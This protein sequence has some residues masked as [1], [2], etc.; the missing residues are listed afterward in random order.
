MSKNVPL[1]KMEEIVFEKSSPF[2]KKSLVAQKIESREMDLQI[3]ED[4]VIEQIFQLVFLMRLPYPKMGGITQ[5]ISRLF[6]SGFGRGK[7]TFLESLSKYYVE[8]DTFNSYVW[9]I[10]NRFDNFEKRMKKLEENRLVLLPIPLKKSHRESLSKLNKFSSWLKSKKSEYEDK[11]I[12]YIEDKEG[13][14]W[15]IIASAETEEDLFKELDRLNTQED[16]K[17]I[18]FDFRDAYGIF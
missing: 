1:T 2:L 4:T 8:I 12:A 3:V 17:V 14:S 9:E 16:Q 18:F 10:N 6:G 5:S 7:R 13:E 15:E 11:M